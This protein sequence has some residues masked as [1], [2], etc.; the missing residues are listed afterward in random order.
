M[1]HPA[2]KLISLVVVSLLST[3]GNWLTLLV[4]GAIMLPFYF[5]HTDYFS[6]AIRMLFKLKWFFASILLIYLFF[7]P[8]ISTPLTHH[9][10]L[11][12][13]LPSL[14]RISVLVI[15]LFAVN[16][17]IKST[18]KEAILASLLWLFSPLKKY[19]LD[20]DRLSLRAVLTLEAIEHLNYKMAHYKN[21]LQTEKIHNSFSD[22]FFN[23]QFRQ[24]I[25][26][27]SVEKKKAFF[28]LVKHSGIILRDILIEADTTSGQSYQI[29]SM[30]PP[31]PVQFF[32][33]A[34][35]TLI[36]LLTL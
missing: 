5:L 7:T 16:L 4:T 26:R 2:I 9:Y 8:A 12:S 28:H 36:L 15:I 6:S 20:I 24:C 29:E 35:L 1:M 10:L 34:L 17:Y 23:K 13:L 33:P 32:I 27:W 18:S 11:A 31:L 30:Q 14:F 25:I 21:S 19:R 22:C 3:Q